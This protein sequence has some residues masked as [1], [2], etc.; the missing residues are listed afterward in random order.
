MFVHYGGDICDGEAVTDILPGT[1]VTIVTDKETYK[2]KSLIVAAGP[3]TSK[4]LQPLGLTL[5][6]TVCSIHVLCFMGSPYP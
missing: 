6:L 1:T 4:L 3:W 5:P 2:A